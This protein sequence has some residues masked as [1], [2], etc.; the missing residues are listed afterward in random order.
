LNR[1]AL[2]F[3]IATT[4]AQVFALVLDA[5]D[6]APN[7][8]DLAEAPKGEAREA[9]LR[10]RAATRRV[11]AQRLGVAPADVEIG[12]DPR[13]APRLLR[14]DAQLCL[15]VS[16][17][18]DFCAIALKSSAIGVDIEPLEAE[19]QPVWSALHS[20]EAALLRALP[21]AVRSEA[22][23]RLWTAKEA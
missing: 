20:S 13:G 23:L 4:D 17:R 8:R 14:P 5:A 1:Q 15:S 11:V 3:R 7:A 6:L 9:F 18:A 16:G 21:E 10:R 2:D 12:R 22:F 19:A